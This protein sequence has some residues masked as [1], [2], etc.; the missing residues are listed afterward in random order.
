MHPAFDF[1]HL[2]GVIIVKNNGGDGHGKA[3]GRNDQGLGNTGRH[4]GQRSRTAHA[5]FMKRGHDAP[6]RPEKTDK[7]GGAAGGGQ[8]RKRLGQSGGFEIF[9]FAERPFQGLHAGKACLQ[10]FIGSTGG[11]CCFA[12]FLEFMVAGPEDVR[13]RTQGEVV[14]EPE[15]FGKIFALPEGI[16]EFFA[17]HF[18][19][20]VQGKFLEHN[21]PR[22]QGEPQEHDHDKF[23]RE[24]GLK[25]H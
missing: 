22:V 13:L 12:E 25:K 7:G 16:Q 19:L 21:E 4:N 18:R 3:C 17:F 23:D 24:S 6:D 15:G 5:Y 1:R 8:K 11:R 20:L 10:G 2:V 14:G 9:R